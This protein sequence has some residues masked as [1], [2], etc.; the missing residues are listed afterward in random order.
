MQVPFKKYLHDCRRMSPWLLLPLILLFLDTPRPRVIDGS[1]S[2]AAFGVGFR[3]RSL[4]SCRKLHWFP[5][6]HWPFF[7]PL[8]TSTFPPSTPPIPF[9][10][11]TTAPV[12][13]VPCL[14]SKFRNRSLLIS[15]PLH[16]GFSTFDSCEPISSDESPCRTI[17]IRF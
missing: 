10:L 8:V 12:S 13:N 3:A 2:A 17:P 7:F 14:A 9:R 4:L 6:E 15:T 5:F 1:E 16:H 11:L